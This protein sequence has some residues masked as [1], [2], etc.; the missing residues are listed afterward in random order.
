MK[1]NGIENKLW[2]LSPK[3]LSKVTG[4]KEC[5]F[6]EMDEGTNGVVKYFVESTCGMDKLMK[7]LEKGEQR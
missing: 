5:V 1:K 6:E 4:I 7:E 3:F 2:T